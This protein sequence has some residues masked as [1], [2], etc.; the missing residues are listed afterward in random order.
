MPLI[1]PIW[2]D[3]W[4]NIPLPVLSYFCPLVIIGCFLISFGHW[5]HAK[6]YTAITIYSLSI[7]THAI[8]RPTVASAEQAALIGGF[9]A[10]AI[11]GLGFVG[12]GLVRTLRLPYGRR[13]LPARAKRR[14]QFQQGLTSAIACVGGV[15]GISLGA[16]VGLA[17]FLVAPVLALDVSLIWQH[18]TLPRILRWS[19]SLFGSVGL[20]VGLLTG[21]GAFNFKQV[22]DRLLIYATIQGFLTLSACKRLLKRLR[23]R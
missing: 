22:G 19:M 12:L 23:G 20:L 11:Y 10:P 18:Q 9:F 1:E 17:L 16:V 3:I 15:T 5:L 21:W 6:G 13:A 2:A 4:A 7:F 14:G 8:I